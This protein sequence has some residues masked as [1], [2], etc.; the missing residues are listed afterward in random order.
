MDRD[1]KYSLDIP[2][3]Y[4]IDVLGCLSADWSASLSGMRI[5]TQKQADGSYETFLAGELI[6]QAALIGVINT[7]YNLGF[8][9]I[10]VRKTETPIE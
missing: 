2:A 7:L 10:S 3:S 6:D 8:T 4:E 5:S 9:L 1:Q